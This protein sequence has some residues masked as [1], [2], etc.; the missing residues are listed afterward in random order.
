[1]KKTVRDMTLQEKLG[2]LILTGLPGTEVDENFV[3]LVREEK[4]GNVILFQYNQREEDQLAALCGGLRELIEA[5]TGLPPLIASDEE[6]GI[7]SRLPETMGKMPSA[8]AL[9]ALGDPRAVYDAALW[10]GRQLRGVGINFV[11]APVLDVNN[12]LKNPVIGVRS[13]GRD[14]QTVS[15]LG[16]EALRGFRDAGILCSGKHFPGHGDTTTDPH[17]GFAR[18]S[19]SREELRQLEL[20]PFHMAVEED[21]PAIMIAHVALTEEDGLPATLSERVIRGLLREELGFD[22][23]A[24]SDCMEMDAVRAGF[25]TAAGAVRSIMAGIDLVCISRSEDQV[26]AA[27]RGLREAAESGAL[28]MAQIDRSVERVLACK[29]RYAGPPPAWTAEKRERCIALAEDLFAGSVACGVQ[30]RDGRFPLG[31]APRFLSPIRQQLS[32]VTEKAVRLSMAEELAAEF[33]GEAREM[34]LRP[35]ERERAEILQW[36]AGGT[37]VVAGTLNATVYPEQMALLEELTKLEV[38]MACVTLR[39]PFELEWMPERVFRI[40]VYEYS[41]RGIRQVCRYLQV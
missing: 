9:A 27:L 37:S 41:R 31:A 20:V 12:N 30:P 3:R 13:F 4:I 22:G 25:G 40:P 16:R 5:E 7:V 24:V 21:I 14:A 1:M 36:V 6:G 39:A 2:Q 10:T 17:I 15:R 29:A 28:P 18:V 19:R 33:G 35:G 34:P 11:L 32:L 38:P 26:R 8:M 23:L